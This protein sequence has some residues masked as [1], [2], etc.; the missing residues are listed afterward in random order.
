[1]LTEQ[2]VHLVRLSGLDGIDDPTVAS[3]GESANEV[4]R[5][6][7][8]SPCKDPMEG[9]SDACIPECPSSSR[10]CVHGQWWIMNSC[11][12]GSGIHGSIDGAGIDWKSGM[13]HCDMVAPMGH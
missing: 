2:S 5:F 11:C 10:P 3:P 8:P 12:G 13:A 9:Q 7:F 1:M 4:R 6:L